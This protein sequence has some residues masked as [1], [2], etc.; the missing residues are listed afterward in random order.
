MDD[1][2]DASGGGGA[3]GSRMACTRFVTGPD[4]VVGE[5]TLRA[6]AWTD[7]H[8]HDE[9]NYVVDGELHVSVGGTETVAG[10]G[11]VVRVPAGDR[12]RYAA[13]EFARMVFVYGPSTDGHAALDTAYEELGG[14]QAGGPF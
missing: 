5:W 9:V 11:M 1:V 13:P 6:A 10:R 4:L 12:A 2:E 7:R 3:V 8:H 14:E